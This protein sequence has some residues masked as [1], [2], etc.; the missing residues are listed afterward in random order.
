M[1]PTKHADLAR[2]FATEPKLR[3]V[4][5]SRSLS[6]IKNEVYSYDT[7]IAK[8]YAADKVGL[9]T[10]KYGTTSSSRLGQVRR[11][12]EAE[13]YTRTA[14]RRH[15]TVIFDDKETRVEFEVWRKA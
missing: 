6:V 8:R 10:A 3:S 12:L 14:E 11:A 1:T 9:T 2:Y 7:M 15:H 4:S 5:G 13:G